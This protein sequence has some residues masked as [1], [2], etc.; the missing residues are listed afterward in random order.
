[1]V[2]DNSRSL[3]KKLRYTITTTPISSGVKACYLVR[4]RPHADAIVHDCAS[5]GV[6][7]FYGSCQKCVPSA[8]LQGS[9]KLKWLATSNLIIRNGGSNLFLQYPGL[10]GQ[11]PKL[12][13][14]YHNKPLRKYLRKQ[15]I[16]YPRSS[17]PPPPPLLFSSSLQSKYIGT[18]KIHRCYRLWN[19]VFSDFHIIPKQRSAMSPVQSSIITVTVV[20]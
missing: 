13:P 10:R 16:D 2:T 15:N 6:R 14:A 12:L 8:T 11:G 18:A 17:A 4:H 7:C 5:P 3:T 20:N 1:V 9:S 19:I